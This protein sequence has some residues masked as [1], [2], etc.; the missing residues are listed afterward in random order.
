MHS[1]PYLLAAGAGVLI[2]HFISRAP[3]LRC[4]RLSQLVLVP[5]VMVLC[6][7]GGV[8]TVLGVVFLAFL[9]APNIACYFGAGLSNFLDSYDWTPT[10]EEMALRPIRLLI[11]R[12][13]YRQALAELD[14]L[15]KKH[16]PTYEAVLL[17]AKLLHHIGRVDETAATLPGLIALSHSTAQQ[18]AVMELLDFLEKDHQDPPKPPGSGTRGIE[19]H[20]ELVLFQLT[21]DTP[22]LHKE[23]PPGTYAIEETLHRNRRWLKLA[24]EDWGNAEVCW[25]AI[26]AIHLPPATPPKK[27]LLWQIARMH[28]AVT[29]AIK[30]KPRR[31][32]Q[33]ESQK[34]FHEAKQF[35]HR[36]DWQNALPL[37]QKASACDP[38]RYE[39]AYRWMLAVRHTAN[40]DV[41]AQAVSQVLQQSQWS[42]N[43]QDMLNQLKQPLAR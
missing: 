42:K 29:T 5:I 39:I 15:L 33:T 17:K 1:I 18:L 41:T 3:E 25:E 43:E 23:I 20:H 7:A 26:L 35:I 30:G 11:D 8:L 28:Q 38:D 40:D 13:N 10:E 34:L 2:A 16:K 36:D 24:G 37:L 14:E 12:D 6:V 9:V 32:L 4:M 22:P 19:I 21:G 27:G 31:Q